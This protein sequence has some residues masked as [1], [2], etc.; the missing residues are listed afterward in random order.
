MPLMTIARAFAVVVLAAGCSKHDSTRAANTDQLTPASRVRSATESIAQSRCDRERRCNNIGADRKYSSE[1]ACLAKIRDDWRDDL[2]A[3]E[4][5]NGINQMQLN[6]C[7]EHI[8]SEDCG[9]PFDTLSRVSECT[10]AQICE[11]TS[12]P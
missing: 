3:R 5:Q 12:G 8:R 2:S 1:S 11:G 10:K 7:L 9:N 6:E 4:C